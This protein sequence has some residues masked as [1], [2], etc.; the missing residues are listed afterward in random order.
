MSQE[1]N[2]I[3]LISQY[4]EMVEK[5]STYSAHGFLSKCAIIL[6]QIYSLGMAMPDSDIEDKDV[7][8]EIV[9]P[10]GSIEILMGK[11]DRYNVVYEPS[12]ED[13]VVVGSLSDDLSDIYLDLKKALVNYQH[14]HK[15]DALWQIKFYL[16]SHAGTHLVDAL[17]VMHRLIEDMDPDYKNV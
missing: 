5:L 4:V 11:Y 16:K 14:G 3:G 15:K 12:R 6:P 1:E 9:S 17:Y 7:D 10:L 8:V 2:I 13:K